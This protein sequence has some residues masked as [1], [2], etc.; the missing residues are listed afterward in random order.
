MNF[1]GTFLNKSELNSQHNNS[2][3]YIKDFKYT[4]DSN[5]IKN[6]IASRNAN[7]GNSK[8]YNSITNLS[9]MSNIISEKNNKNKNN[10]EED[11][12]NIKSNKEAFNDSLHMKFNNTNNIKQINLLKLTKKSDYKNS[13]LNNSLNN[14]QS[15]KEKIRNKSNSLE[16]IKN[17]NNK[18]QNYKKIINNNCNKFKEIR[19]NKPRKIKRTLSAI[20]KKVQRDYLNS[21]GKILKLK[22]DEVNSIIKDNEMDNKTIFIIKKSP[23]KFS[24]KKSM[25][26]FKVSNQIQSNNFFLNKGYRCKGNGSTLTRS[27]S[28]L[29][30]VKK[31]GN[32]NNNIII[33]NGEFI[34][35]NFNGGIDKNNKIH[36][37][38]ISNL[39]NNNVNN[40]SI[41]KLNSTKNGVN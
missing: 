10:F 40:V 23:K 38:L 13:I 5:N 24:E 29:G 39:K 30:G 17:E 8:K 22:R 32:I 12:G 34:E 4:M 31:D 35:N 2:F 41:K 18:Y 1:N 27:I 14:I 7:E 36:C 6:I 11:I 25:P 33:I 26:N 28:N 20:E 9:N 16:D 3:E 37:P 21:K 15:N 19:T